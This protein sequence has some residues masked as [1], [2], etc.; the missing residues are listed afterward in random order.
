MIGCKHSNH[1]GRLLTILCLD[2]SL[3]W[4]CHKD[5]DKIRANVCRMHDKFD[6]RVRLDPSG[7][8]L[9][10]ASYWLGI[11]IRSWPYWGGPRDPNTIYRDIIYIPFIL[12][13]EKRG[14]R[15]GHYYACYFLLFNPI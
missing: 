4:K 5:G 13:Q 14:L 9:D 3:S 12:G 7:N 6:K 15:S 11:H 2:K 10:L 8:G 1:V